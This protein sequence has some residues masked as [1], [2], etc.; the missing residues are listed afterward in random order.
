[1]GIGGACVEVGRETTIGK[2]PAT[3]RP[4]TPHCSVLAAMLEEQRQ[5]ILATEHT[6]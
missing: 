2:T 4:D 5:L 1:M 6:K 3:A